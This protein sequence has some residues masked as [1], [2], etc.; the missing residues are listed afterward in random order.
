MTSTELPPDMV[1]PDPVVIRDLYPARVTITTDTP[2][3]PRVE[4]YD[5]VK[6][7]VTCRRVYVYVGANNPHPVKVADWT[8]DA[9]QY[10]LADRPRRAN[11]PFAVRVADRAGAVTVIEAVHA[12]GCGC[13]DLM[14]HWRPGW[15]R[16]TG[17]LPD[18]L[19]PPA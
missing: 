13:G 6:V 7:F 11:A 17:P 9:R 4:T 15:A 19:R 8:P 5:R 1:E 18:S 2:T 14:K 12:G 10:G 3:G 16:K